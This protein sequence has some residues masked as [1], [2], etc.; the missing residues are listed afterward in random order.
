VKYKTF[1]LSDTGGAI[2]SLNNDR[3]L[4]EWRLRAWNPPIRGL[5][6]LLINFIGF[7]HSFDHGI[8]TYTEIVAPTYIRFTEKCRFEKNNLFLE[9]EHPRAFDLKNMRIGMIRRTMAGHLKRHLY[10]QARMP[11]VPLD[12]RTELLLKLKD[13]QSAQVFLKYND[14]ATDEIE[15]LSPKGELFNPPLS[16]HIHLDPDFSKLLNLLYGQGGQKGRDFE[17]ALAVLL[18][19]AGFICCPYGVTSSLQE[20]PDVLAFLHGMNQVIVCEC[21]TGP[22]DANSKLSKLVKR[23]KELQKKYPSLQWR[24]VIFTPDEFDTVL[25]SEKEK[26]AMEGIAIVAREHIVEILSAVKEGVQ[27]KAIL[28]YLPGLVPTRYS[29]SSPFGIAGSRLF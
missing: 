10:R 26:A 25:D 6:D 17:G 9:I 1:I 20:A 29:S 16:A 12:K 15:V 28:E 13:C 27:A 8:N 2:Q 22:L 24:P 3:E 21:T 5:E 14:D 18:G 23:T 19:L 4:I 11:I 7:T